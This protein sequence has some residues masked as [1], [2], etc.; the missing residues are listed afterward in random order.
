MTDK[1]W[2]KLVRVHE[3]E[4]KKRFGKKRWSMANIGWYTD[5]ISITSKVYGEQTSYL[6]TRIEDSRY[7]H[8]EG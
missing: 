6:M 2:D 1:E 4:G 7:I 5:D 8:E 3:A